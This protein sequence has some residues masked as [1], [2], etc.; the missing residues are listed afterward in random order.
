M[1]LVHVLFESNLLGLLLEDSVPD[2]TRMLHPLCHAARSSLLTYRTH[3][4][5]IDPSL[6]FLFRHR[7]IPSSAASAV[8]AQLEEESYEAKHGT[9]PYN[10][11]REVA[12]SRQYRCDP[13]S[14]HRRRPGHL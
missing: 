12:E 11:R 5:R 4:G 14:P 8:L 9:D 13:A 2:I 1:R 3:N 6:I 10:T 7:N